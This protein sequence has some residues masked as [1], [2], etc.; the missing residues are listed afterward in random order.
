MSAVEMLNLCGGGEQQEQE[1]EI[2]SV[3]AQNEIRTAVNDVE[4]SRGETALLGKFMEGAAKGKTSL[5]LYFFF[6]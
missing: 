3:W 5:F 2:A 6:V 4:V 1:K